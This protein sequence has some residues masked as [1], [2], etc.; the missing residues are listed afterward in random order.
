MLI[1]AM[2]SAGREELTGCYSDRQLDLHLEGDS[3]NTYWGVLDALVITDF[4][5]M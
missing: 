1:S 3:A 2:T 5:D 4:P